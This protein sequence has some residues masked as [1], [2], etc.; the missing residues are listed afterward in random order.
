MAFSINVS[1]SKRLSSCFGRA[2]RLSGQKRVP[3]PPARMRAKR[4]DEVDMSQAKRGA[5]CASRKGKLI[6]QMGVQEVEGKVNSIP[7][8]SRLTS[9]ASF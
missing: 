4:L 5:A 6:V 1:S 3:L 9:R 2:F 7:D 8:L